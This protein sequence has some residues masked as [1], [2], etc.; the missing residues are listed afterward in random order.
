MVTFLQ[1]KRSFINVMDCGQPGFTLSE[2]KRFGLIL[3]EGKLVDAYRFLHKDKDMECGFS[4]SGNP[5][6]K[7]RGKRMRI[8]YFIISEKLNDRI[9]AC[10]IHG[11]GIELR[12]FY[13][14]DHCPVSLE[15][16][17]P[18]PDADQSQ[19]CAKSEDT[20]S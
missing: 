6:G 17:D 13:G 9:V 2:R 18:T 8:D 12:G 14:S 4:W 1:I 10:E 16:S 19:V 7:Y 15:L 20:G 5:V 11:Q 3:K